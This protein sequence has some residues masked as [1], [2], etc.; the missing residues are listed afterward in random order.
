MV[1]FTL[2]LLAKGL[3]SLRGEHVASMKLK[4]HPKT[5]HNGH[6][7]C[8]ETTKP[9]LLRSNFSVSI[10][11]PTTYHTIQDHRAVT[12]FVIG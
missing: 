7:L 5:L 4:C 8:S 9:N 10:I 12:V 11:K 3:H 1:A 6:H 2:A